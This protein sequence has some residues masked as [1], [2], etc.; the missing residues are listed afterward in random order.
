M[1]WS[2]GKKA[3]SGGLCTRGDH[4]DNHGPLAIRAAKLAIDKGEQM[5]PETALDFERQ[6]YETILG[7][8]DRLE[9]LHAFAEKRE[10]VYRGE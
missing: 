10:P 3:T 5:D 8:K 1:R 2:A 6:C 9:G 7:T 4:D